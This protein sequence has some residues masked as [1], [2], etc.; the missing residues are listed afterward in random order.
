MCEHGWARLN[1]QARGILTAKA[2]DAEAIIARV[3]NRIATLQNGRV[4]YATVQNAQEQAELQ[5]LIATRRAARA[6]KA[7]YFDCVLQIDEMC[8]WFRIVL[9]QL[10]SLTDDSLN[11]AGGTLQNLANNDAL[12][13]V[14]QR[15]VTAA[16]AA[17]NSALVENESFAFHFHYGSN[18]RNGTARDL[19]VTADQVRLGFGLRLHM[20]DIGAGTE[21]YNYYLPFICLGVDNNDRINAVGEN[22]MINFSQ[23]AQEADH[24]TSTL[25]IPFTFSS[26]EAN[27]NSGSIQKVDLTWDQDTGPDPYLSIESV[28]FPSSTAAASYQLQLPQYE[29]RMG[30]P[31]DQLG[32]EDGISGNFD[33]SESTTRKVTFSNVITNEVFGVCYVFGQIRQED[34]YAMEWN[35]WKPRIASCKIRV[36]NNPDLTSHLNCYTDGTKN[37]P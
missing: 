34:R 8:H 32:Q 16:E 17:L 14:T 19:T 18:I 4:D 6:I 25:E 26:A 5:L 37:A 33:F 10:F 30:I 1:F 31:S 3:A 21:D 27:S 11:V 36:G 23:E 15:T 9:M 2:G 12:R 22:S 28:E 24:H 13:Y 20:A 35:E 29:F 7:F